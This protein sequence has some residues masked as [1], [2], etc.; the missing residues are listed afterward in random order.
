M[1]ACSYDMKRLYIDTAC[2]VQYT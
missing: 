2:C 1:H